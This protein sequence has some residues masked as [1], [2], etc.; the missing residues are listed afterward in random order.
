MLTPLAE[1]HA[2]HE[3]RK[4]LTSTLLVKKS[5]AGQLSPAKMILLQ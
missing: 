2:R 1:I 3:T 4:A 5:L